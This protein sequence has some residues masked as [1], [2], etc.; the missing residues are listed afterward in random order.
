MVTAA[1][2]AEPVSVA[3]APAV[4]VAALV[5][6]LVVVKEA[7]TPFGK[8]EGALK[9]TAPLKLLNGTMLI[10]PAAVPL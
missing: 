6:A 1:G 9:L 5:V 10:V 4:N 7:V 2:F 3:D 8:P